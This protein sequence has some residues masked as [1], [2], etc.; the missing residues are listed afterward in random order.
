MFP[1]PSPDRGIRPEPCNRGRRRPAGKTPRPLAGARGARG[2]G[3]GAPGAPAP[4]T[5]HTF[6]IATQEETRGNLRGPFIRDYFKSINGFEG[7]HDG[8]SWLANY[9]GHPM[10]GAVYGYTYLQNHT[11]EK[12]LPVDF[13]SRDYWKSRFKAM[14]WMTVAS[15]HYE[16][17]PLGEAAFG[18]TGLRPGTKGA[19]DLV[20][21]PTL[22]LS[23]LIVEDF[24][25]DRV[26]VPLERR[27]HNKF[28]RLFLRSALNPD[29]AMANLLRFKVPWHR[30]T[31]AGVGFQS[32]AFPRAR[33]GP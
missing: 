1:Y 28:L 21:T 14:A 33:K 32:D 7:W 8:D 31:R 29:R 26:V 30:D 25:D 13:H 18:N 2:G 10:Q 6:R 23:L 22:G 15:T 19:V 17:G 16:L 11:R 3:A 20:I 5:Q 27:I 12:F 24:L 9:V 4:R